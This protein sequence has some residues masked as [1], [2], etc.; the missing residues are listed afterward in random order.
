MADPV[1]T[2]PIDTRNT[3]GLLEGTPLCYEIH[4][5][6]NTYLNLVSDDCTSV[7]ARY[8][9]ATKAD[10]NMIRIIGVVATDTSN[11]CH[12]IQIEVNDNGRCV[13]Q[14]DGTAVESN[15]LEMKGVMVNHKNS[16]VRISVPNCAPPRRHLVMWVRCHKLTLKEELQNGTIVVVAFDQP[17]IKFVISRGLNHRAL[18]HGLIGELPIGRVITCTIS[19]INVLIVHTCFMHT[20]HTN[21]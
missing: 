5:K 19:G 20:L 2:V 12:Y 17:S 6:N 11:E 14:M 10:I 9:G 3:S 18:A 8:M 16:L 13:A 15:G 21:A 1:F 7:N 4:G